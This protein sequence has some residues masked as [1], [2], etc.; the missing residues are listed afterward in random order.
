MRSCRLLATLSLL[1]PN[2]ARLGRLIRK[3]S[4]AG[5]MPLLSVLSLAQT[6]VQVNNNTV[7]ANASTVNVTYATAE[8]V[9]DLNVVVVGWSDT[10]SSVISVVD[11]NTNNYVLVGTTS[12]HGLSQA[13][14]YARNIVLPNNATPTVTVTFN[15]TAGFPDVRILEYS[16]LSA[17]A[18]LDNWA[19][20]SGVS[21]GADSSGAATTTSDLVLGA[22]TTTSAFTMPGVGFTSRV[23]TT[24]FGDIVEDSNGAVAAGTY[25]ATATIA[26]PKEWVMQVVGFSTTGVSFVSPPTISPTTPITPATGTDVGGTSVTITG[27]NFQ[28]GAVVLFG[29]APGGIS[30]VNCTESGGT[31][32]TCLTP[33]D[34]DGAKDVTVVNVDGQSSSATG[35]FTF[36]NVTPVI[37]TIAPVTGPTNGGTA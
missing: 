19:G 21:T 7:A 28:P 26:A 23:I 13:I 4:I 3:I 30:G 29:T 36:Q 2:S 24:P 8:T 6:F 12:G 14:Y 27:T 17:T 18:P 16:G 37:S 22:G 33:A 1:V 25:N 31:T 5:S 9:G 32:I 34:T 20:S 15:Q 11:D 10:S 35:A